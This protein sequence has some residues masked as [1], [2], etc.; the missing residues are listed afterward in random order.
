MTIK[1]ILKQPYFEGQENFLKEY[2]LSHPERIKWESWCFR[3]GTSEVIVAFNHSR[4]KCE[5]CLEVSGT[6]LYYFS[7]LKQLGSIH[8]FCFT[9]S[10]KW[11]REKALRRKL[12]NPEKYKKQYAKTNIKNRKKNIAIREKVIDFYTNGL[13]KC[14]CCGYSGIQFLN[15]DHVN[16]DGYRHRKQLKGSSYKVY[17]DIINDGFPDKY[18]ILCFNCNLAKNHNGGVCPHEDIDE[19]LIE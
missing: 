14:M 3:K 7:N 4:I 16:N 1:S 17:Q 11:A 15:V 2:Y 9:K 10:K 5:V 19:V 6:D 12:R 18:Q 13:R 8:Q